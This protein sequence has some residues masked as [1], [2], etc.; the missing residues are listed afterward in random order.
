MRQSKI[1]KIFN[2]IELNYNNISTQIVNWLSLAYNKSGILFNSSSPYGQILEVIKETFRQNIL[3][4]KNTVRQLD[5][6]QANNKRM[7]INTARISGHNPSR[8]LS[9]KGTLKLKLKQGINI[10]QNVIGEKIIIYDNTII[11]NNSNSLFYTIKV[12]SDKNFYSLTPGCQFYLNIIQGRYESQTFTGDGTYSQSFQINIDNNSTIDNFEFQVKLN[13][14]TLTIKDHLND[15]LNNEYA[16]YS[17]T[18]FNGG[19]DIYF[20]NGINGIVPP[21]GSIIEVTYLLT[22]GLNG[23]IYN[24]KINDFVFIDDVY[25]SVGNSIEPI[26]LFDIFIETDIK[27]ASDG[28][29]I[30]YMKSVVPYVSRNFVLATPSQFIYHLKKLNMFSKVNAFNTLDMIKIDIDSDGKLD[31]ININEMYL[32]LI[33]RITD[34][35]STDINYFNVP[36]EYFYLQENEKQRIITYLKKQGILSITSSLKIINPII[37]RYI[38]HLFITRYEDVEKD[39][40]REQIISLLSDY[41]SN[42]TRHDRI[43]KADLIYNLKNIEGIDSLNLEFVSKENEDYHRDGAILSSTKKNVVD[44]TFTS[45]KNSVNIKTEKYK[46]MLKIK[47]N[48]NVDNIITDSITIDKESAGLIS[49]GDSTIVSY[50]KIEQYDNKKM[51]GVDPILGDIII[52]YNE[53]VI[54]RGG[55]KNRNGVYFNEDP[56]TNTGFSTVNIIWKGETSRK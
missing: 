34:Y 9:A 45:Y 51:I 52:G 12:G 22:N 19:L 14:V 20:G 5:I 25:D 23:N 46:N 13:G 32:Y 18:G 1:N 43:I 35:F 4:L 26:E 28:E 30:E 27:F 50:S 11:K 33:P 56:K 44:S 49:N 55:W 6:E 8:A 42:Y 53:L 10:N 47:N 2:R 17:R 41:F 37:K 40:I 48:D 24:N 31:D 38:V 7:I 16:C 39:N 3:Y 21:L 54:L 36:F 15:L 29:S